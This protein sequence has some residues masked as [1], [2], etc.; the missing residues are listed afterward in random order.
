M[1]FEPKRLVSPPNLRGYEKALII[2]LRKGK[3]VEDVLQIAK[4]EG[5]KLLKCKRVSVTEFFHS[6]FDPEKFIV[7]V[8]NADVGIE[9]M[10]PK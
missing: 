5:A 8:Q 2:R 9:N 4:V 7:V 1:S 3:F 10:K 6:H